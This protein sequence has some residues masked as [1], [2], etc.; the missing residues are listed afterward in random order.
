MHYW[1]I[2]GASRG[3]GYGFAQNLLENEENY[4]FGLSRHRP[5]VWDEFPQERCM[6]M[7]VDLLD[8][9]D[10]EKKTDTIFAHIANSEAHSIT[11]INNAG[12]VG[13]S[14]R[15]GQLK[16]STIADTMTLNTAVPIWLT[17]AFVAHFQQHAVTK[18][19]LFISSGASHRPMDAYSVY[20][21]SKAGVTHFSANLASE[22]ERFEHPIE[23]YAIAPGVVHTRMVKGIYN[24]NPDN[25]ELVE[26]FHQLKAE[27]G[28]YDEKTAAARV[29]ELMLD[30]DASV[31]EFHDIRSWPKFND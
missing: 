12:I 30:P 16:T 29:L 21:A 8:F 11:L 15:I 27:D 18:R 26:R 13:D 22:Q 20:S 6:F 31:G 14:G 28:M 10:M 4:V 9:E 1:I 17:N 24:Q 23:S 2:T 5:D 25:S 7:E 19:V 3:L